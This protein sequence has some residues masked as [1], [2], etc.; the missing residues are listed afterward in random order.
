M[1]GSE[2]TRA[3]A[4]NCLLALEAQK[5]PVPQGYVTLALPRESLF[6]RP[7]SKASKNGP[8][9]AAFSYVCRSITMRVGAPASR[10]SQDDVLGHRRNFRHYLHASHRVK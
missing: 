6:S 7:V 8:R 1:D 10:V 2:L 3:N 5:P 9:L 4:Q